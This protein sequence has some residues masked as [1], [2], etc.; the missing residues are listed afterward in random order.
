MYRNLSTI[1][2][3]AL[4]AGAL[5]Q[6]ALA[7]ESTASFETLDA[8]GNGAISREEASNNSALSAAWDAA[9][10]NQDGQLDMT[11]F[12]AMEISDAPVPPKDY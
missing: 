7:G 3:A 11:E 8:D 2:I 1:S 6:P 5:V 10:A 12:S 4:F 9:D